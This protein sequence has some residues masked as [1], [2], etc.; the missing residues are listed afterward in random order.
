MHELKEHVF[1]EARD[2]MTAIR[3]YEERLNRIAYEQRRLNQE[4][5]DQDQPVEAFTLRPVTITSDPLVLL[6]GMGPL[7]GAEGFA[8][9]CL[10]YPQGKEIVLFQACSTPNRS[11]AIESIIG[12]RDCAAEKRA[13]ILRSLSASIVEAVA[14]VQSSERMIDLIVLCNASHYFLDDVLERLRNS[15]QDIG[16]RLRFISLI[17]S[18]IAA[19]EASGFKRIMA[20]YTEGTK[21]SRIYSLALE[22]LGIRCIE[23][24]DLQPLLTS[25]I[26]H[27]VKAFDDVLTVQ[28]GTQLF[29]EIVKS[30]QE[31]DCILMGCTEVPLIVEKLRTGGHEDIKSFLSRVAVLDPVAAAL[32]SI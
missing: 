18:T 3:Q 11:V 25:S 1:R 4:P 8:Q 10:S 29:R 14:H 12:E 24:E 19:I 17:E 26:Y 31:F 9:G 13:E 21:R 20:L 32:A 7:A 22:K 15:Y 30:E 2:A 23:R 5:S 27:G 28:L 16:S 6:G